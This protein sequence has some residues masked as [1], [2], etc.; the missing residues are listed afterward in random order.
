VV[1]HNLSRVWARARISVT[2][3]GAIRELEKG[4]GQHAVVDGAALASGFGLLA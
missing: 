4:K 2:S 3:S 1:A